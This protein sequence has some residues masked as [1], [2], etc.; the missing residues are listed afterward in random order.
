MGLLPRRHVNDGQEKKGMMVRQNLLPPSVPSEL[1]NLTTTSKE[2]QLKV[3]LVTAA[4][5]CCV[6]VPAAPV[7]QGS[8]SIA[9]GRSSPENLKGLCKDWKYYVITNKMTVEKK[10]LANL[11]A[12]GSARQLKRMCC[13]YQAAW[14]LTWGLLQHENSHHE[15]TTPLTF[16]SSSTETEDYWKSTLLS[17]NTAYISV[18]FQ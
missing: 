12:A 17:E 9:I 8:G 13:I 2:W 3:T 10:G 16:N 18:P 6:H 15:E 1:P 11:R 7:L 4:K 5:L 14:L